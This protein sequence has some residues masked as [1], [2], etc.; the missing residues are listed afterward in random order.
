MILQ[1]PRLCAIWMRFAKAGSRASAPSL[2]IAS[3]LMFSLTG[4][5]AAPT[6]TPAVMPTSAPAVMP[7]SAPATGARLAEASAALE[8]G[9]PTM[10]EQAYR[11]AV[12]A[13]PKSADA[14]VGLGK[15]DPVLQEGD[16]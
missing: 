8:R 10:A 15:D 4:C 11:S 9:D 2:L 16:Q 13:D 6:Q 3:L 14:Q 7:T 12:E 1:R 5:A